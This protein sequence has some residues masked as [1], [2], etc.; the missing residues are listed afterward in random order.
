VI[1]TAVGERLYHRT[2]RLVAASATSDLNVR[3]QVRCSA[4]LGFRTVTAPDSCDQ[5]G[6][7]P[8]WRDGSWRDC[9]ERLAGPDARTVPGAR[10]RAGTRRESVP[11]TAVT[12]V[13]H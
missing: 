2:Q 11:S 12:P 8:L 5:P 9:F 10:M 1:S 6:P 4:D 13:M 7:R 3:S